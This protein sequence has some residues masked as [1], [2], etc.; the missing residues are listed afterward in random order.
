MAANRQ[1]THDCVRA[2]GTFFTSTIIAEIDERATKKGL[3]CP[4]D[5]DGQVILEYKPAVTAVMAVTTPSPCTDPTRMSSRANLPGSS[6]GG[7][8]VPA[9]RTP[10]ARRRVEA[11]AWR[12]GQ[13]QVP[14][15]WKEGA[16]RE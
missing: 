3:A 12:S 15:R 14:A 6:V 10:F 7:E 9:Q 16:M 2:G 1:S 8:P 5:G 11:H 13:T 4:H